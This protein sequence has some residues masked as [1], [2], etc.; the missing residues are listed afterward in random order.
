MFGLLEGKKRKGRERERERVQ[1]M[2]G[3]NRRIDGRTA[4]GFYDAEI[5]AM[6]KNKRKGAAADSLTD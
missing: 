5:M 1:R 6:R 2:Q 3:E 4:R